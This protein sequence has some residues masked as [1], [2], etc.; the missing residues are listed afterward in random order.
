MQTKVCMIMSPEAEGELYCMSQGQHNNIFH[1]TLF[2]AKGGRP[3]SS[4]HSAT[5]HALGCARHC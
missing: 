2:L 4:N 3:A 5:K 1:K